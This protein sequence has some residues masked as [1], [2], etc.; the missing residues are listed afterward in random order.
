MKTLAPERCPAPGWLSR[1]AATHC[2]DLALS[3]QLTFDVSPFL[4]H[5][6]F[7]DC[8]SFAPRE[9]SLSPEALLLGDMLEFSE[10]LWDDGSEDDGVEGDELEG[11]F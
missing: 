5:F 4:G 9:V 3:L 11:V 6:F 2:G 8:C 7:C 1:D 10:G